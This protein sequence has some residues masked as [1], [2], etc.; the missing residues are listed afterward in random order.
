MMYDVYLT[1][2]IRYQSMV[3]FHV[4]VMQKDQF[5][6]LHYVIILSRPCHCQ[7]LSQ[8]YIYTYDYFWHGNVVKLKISHH[9]CY[10]IIS[11]MKFCAINFEISSATCLP[12]VMSF[13]KKS[14]H[15]CV[16][17]AIRYDTGARTDELPLTK[18][19]FRPQQTA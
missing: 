17:S 8:H 18:Q 6:I 12:Q 3:L 19:P 11:M 16:T 10:C 13:P 9:T 15:S 4:F 7:H 14:L 1:M 2:K 5:H